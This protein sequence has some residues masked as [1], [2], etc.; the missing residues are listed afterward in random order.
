M[1]VTGMYFTINLMQISIVPIPGIITRPLRILD[2]VYLVPGAGMN[3]GGKSEQ[4]YWKTNSLLIPGQTVP[5]SSEVG[6]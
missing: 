4:P 1:D 6:C 3:A 5:A 2:Y